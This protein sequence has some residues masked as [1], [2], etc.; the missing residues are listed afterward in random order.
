MVPSYFLDFISPTE[1]DNLL[2]G[3]NISDLSNAISSRQDVL[4]LMH[5]DLL[6]L[7]YLLL[8]FIY[9]CKKYHNKKYVILLVGTLVILD[10]WSINKRYLNKDS[11]VDEF[12]YNVVKDNEDLKIIENNKNRERVYDFTDSPFSSAMASYFHHS[13]GGYSAAK[14]KRYQEIYENYLSRQPIIKSFKDTIIM[15]PKK[16]GV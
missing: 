2:R 4:H 8:H 11:F 1:K 15:V 12:T 7:F 10:M 5:G 6:C 3:Q 13:I 14:I 16:M 9:V